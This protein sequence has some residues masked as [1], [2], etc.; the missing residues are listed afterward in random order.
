MVEDVS[1]GLAT[2][3]V[4]TYIN[5][6]VLQGSGLGP[7]LFLIYITNLS[8]KQWSIVMYIILQMIQT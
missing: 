4:I 2:A 3:Q 1:E 8:T 7:L 5:Y 6:G